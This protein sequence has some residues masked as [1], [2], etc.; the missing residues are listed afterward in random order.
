[1]TDQR[2]SGISCACPSCSAVNPVSLAD[3]Q[4]VVKCLGC[5]RDFTIREALRPRAEPASGSPPSTPLAPP[6]PSTRTR[7]AWGPGIIVLVLLLAVTIWLLV[8]QQKAELDALRAFC[9]PVASSDSGYPRTGQTIRNRA[10]IANCPSQPNG[11]DLFT[12]LHEPRIG[13][14]IVIPGA[15]L[16]ELVAPIRGHAWNPRLRVWLDHHRSDEVELGGGLPLSALGSRNIAH[17]GLEEMARRLND[18][19]GDESAAKAMVD[20]FAG[21]PGTEDQALGRRMLIEDE[22]P[23]QFILRPFKGTG[24]SRL[25]DEGRPPY[26]AAVSAYEGLLLRCVGAGWPDR[27]RVLNLRATKG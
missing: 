13:S 26:V 9:L 22:F 24:A 21:I 18:G 14:V 8:P 5:G 15:R 27:Y 3:P 10:W 20:L 12:R 11:V 16:R 1:M 4:A 2:P 19:L 7:S 25:I 17:V 6:A 23:D